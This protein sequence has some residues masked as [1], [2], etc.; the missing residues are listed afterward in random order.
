MNDIAIIDG[1]RTPFV[2]SWT[3]FTDIDLVTLSKMVVK[4]L[5]N[6]IDLPENQITDIIF[7]TVFPPTYSPNIAREIILNSDLHKGISGF[8]VNRACASGIQAITCAFDMIYRNT[9]KV[10]IAG[11][12]DSVSK[13]DFPVSN[14]I[15]EFLRSISQ[16]NDIDIKEK[17][18][19]L[20]PKIPR[21]SELS[22]GLTMGEYADI[23]ALENNISRIEQDV[24][25]LSSHK[26]ATNAINNSHFENEIITVNNISID[27]NIR[28]DTS[29]E[30]LSKLKPVFKKDGSVTAGNSSPLTDG[31][32]STIL[33]SIQKAKEL[34]YKPKAIIQ[35]Y[36]YTAIDTHGQ[37]LMGNS[38]SIPLLLKRNNLKLEDIDF[39]EIHEAFASQVLS[40]INAL[41]SE[42]FSQKE[43]N[44][45]TIGLI[46]EE[47][48]NIYG[49]S[50]AIGHP[51]GATGIRLVN[52]MSNILKKYDKKLGIV[53]VCAAGGMSAA[54]LIRNF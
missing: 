39:F 29:L 54:L 24:F 30:S 20:I 48:L 34:G 3:D 1:L 35:D 14:E 17:S 18:L 9:E 31:A 47:K 10:I 46:P 15:K 38:Y 26:K 12:C 19:K 7:G 33:M 27:N 22:T 37:M 52:T 50:I 4:G 6:K 28:S 21:L 36:V 25:S 16:T 23:M 51:F 13:M 32:G 42:E 2:K 53:S 5:I 8:T 43:L 45:P 40:N 44:S 49:G 41:N 11:G